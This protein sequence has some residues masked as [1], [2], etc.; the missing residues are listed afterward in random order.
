VHFVDKGLSQR[1]IT[2]R[3]VASNLPLGRQLAGQAAADASRSRPQAERAAA[4]PTC[5][6]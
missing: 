1:E 2:E 4:A 6:S 3:I 5:S